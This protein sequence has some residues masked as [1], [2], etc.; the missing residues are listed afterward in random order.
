LDVCGRLR[1]GGISVLNFQIALL[2]DSNLQSK[3]LAFFIERETGRKCFV[4]E[5]YDET[6]P[7]NNSS[8]GV[9][10]LYDCFER[11]NETIMTFIQTYHQTSPSNLL[12][13]FN[14]NPDLDIENDA[15]GYG[16]RGF[17]Y[18]NEKVETLQKAISAVFA[19]EIW[20]SRKAMTECVLSRKTPF[21]KNQAILTLRE[22]EILSTLAKGHSNKAI[23][24]DL[25]VSTHT[26]KSHIANIYKKINVRN[27]RQAEQWFDKNQ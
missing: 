18:A 17:I 20:I 8:G 1:D 27:R 9:L 13:L 23:A 5:S 14:L 24:D 2:S 22:R 15:F 26:V 11:C 19:G 6:L 21:K 3:L 10:Y 4:A 12:L 16:V 25:C 7:D